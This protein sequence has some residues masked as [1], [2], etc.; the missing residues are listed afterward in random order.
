MF[1]SLPLWVIGLLFFGVMIITLEFGFRI[2][3]TRRDTWRNPEAG[4]GGIVQTSTF[5]VLGLVLAFTYS[6]GLSRFE[7]RKAALL[8]ETNAIGTAF[9]R[10][11]LAA[12]P[13]R[14]LLMHSLYEY[15]AT[16]SIPPRS[17]RSREDFEDL[18]ART[19][20][21]QARIWPATKQ[22]VSG[23]NS[24]PLEPSIV[25]SVNSVLDAHTVRMA[26]VF[27]RLHPTVVWLLVLVA[28]SAMTVAGYNAGIQ[29][30]VSR[31]RM[32]AFSIVLAALTIV[33]LD[34]DRPN[35]GSI[36][37]DQRIM[38]ILIADMHKALN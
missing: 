13:G 11:D 22:V 20:D 21:K 15:A 1:D 14:S 36:I 30:R 18:V 26:A 8:E 33:I 2:G 28:A 34:L 4:G 27:D 23:E 31:L 6:A 38:N 10:A 37:V 25:A 12:E 24:L 19:L 7:A 35:D 9:L 29:G 3:R 32:G 17:I 16:R 5:A